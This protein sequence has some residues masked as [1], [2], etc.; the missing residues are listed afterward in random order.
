MN[1]WLFNYLIKW[2]RQK[3]QTKN[4]RV[5][6][7]TS[8]NLLNR[9]NKYHW[10]SKMLTEL[11]LDNKTLDNIFCTKIIKSFFI[12][13]CLLWIFQMQKSNKN[14]TFSNWKM[15][16]SNHNF[17][18]LSQLVTNSLEFWFWIGMHFNFKVQIQKSIILHKH[19]QSSFHNTFSIT[20]E[21][22]LKIIFRGYF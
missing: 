12:I 5:Q 1:V 20:R 3:W 11:G 21:F 13:R 8:L 7:R 19:T 9:V 6:S 22:D 10:V 18:F 2:S 16:R 4:V 14:L 17:T 15:I